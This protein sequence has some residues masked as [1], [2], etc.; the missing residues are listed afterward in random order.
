MTGVA[1]DLSKSFNSGT[2]IKYVRNIAKARW[3]SKNLILDKITKRFLNNYGQLKAIAP[4]S[5]LGEPRE[6]KV[7]TPVLIKD[8]SSG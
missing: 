5:H 7:R 6:R 4:P 8:N 3:K 1:F 2:I